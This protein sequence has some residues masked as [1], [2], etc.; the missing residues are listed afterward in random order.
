MRIS[1]CFY[2]QLVSNDKRYHYHT[3]DY[4]TPVRDNLEKK[5]TRKINKTIIIL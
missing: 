2:T 5:Q 1:E 3:N 4:T